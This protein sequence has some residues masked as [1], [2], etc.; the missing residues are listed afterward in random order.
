MPWLEGLENY[1]WETWVASILIVA[2]FWLCILGLI[3]YLWNRS[4][5]KDQEQK[6]KEN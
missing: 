2:A 5:K 1:T 6:V 3:V 4:L